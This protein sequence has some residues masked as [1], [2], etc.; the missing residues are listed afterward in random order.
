M[1]LG[2]G[3]GTVSDLFNEAYYAAASAPARLLESQAESRL[4]QVLSREAFEVVSETVKRWNDPLR[5]LVRAV[6]AL[7]LADE[8]GRTTAN[9]PVAIIDGLPNPLAEVTS[10]IET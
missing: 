3:V 6:T 1:A 8:S 2:R 7:K 10:E 5:K 9:V 4:R